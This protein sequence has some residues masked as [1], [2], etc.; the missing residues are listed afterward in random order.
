MNPPRFGVIAFTA[1]LTLMGAGAVRAS[2]PPVEEVVRGADDHSKLPPPPATGGDPTGET[3]GDDGDPS[4]RR[5]EEFEGHLL[6]GQFAHAKERHDEAI[7]EFTAALKLQPGDPTALIGRAQ[8]RRARTPTDRCPTRAIHDLRLLETYDPRGAWLEQRVTLLQW[9]A[10][11]GSAQAAGELA[12]AKEI[13]AEAP[14]SPGRPEDIRVRVAQLQVEAAADEATGGDSLRAAAVAELERYRA[15]C[16]ASGRPPSAEGLR[17]QAEIYRENDDVERA[18]KVYRELLASHPGS[19]QAQGVAGLLDDLELE[20]ELQRLN[21][22]RGFGPTADAEAAYRRG[23]SSFRSGDVEAAATQ[24]E[25]A[26]AASP[27]FPKAY[28]S[29]G[30]VR[31]RQARFAEAVD[32]LQR[33]VAMDPTDYQA[34]ITLGLIYKKEFAGAEDARAIKHLAAA[35]RLRPDLLVLH[36]RLGEL[37]ARTDREKAQEHYE[38][39]V[40]SAEPSDPDVGRAQRALEDL[41]REIQRDEPVA[42]MPPAEASLRA[43][44][45][46][47]QRIIN[48][49]YLR[50]T[51]YQDLAQAEKILLDALDRFPDEPEVYNQ[52][53]RVA[54]LQDRLGDARRYWETSLTLAADQ[55]EVHERIGILLVREMPDEAI[56]HLQRA[57]DLGSLTARY[58][59]AELLWDQTRPWQASPELDRYLAE[60]GEYEAHYDKAVALREE[61]DRRLLQYYLASAI[62]LVLVSIWPTW[63]I[64][65]RYRG[66]SLGQLLERDPKSFPEVARILSLIRHEIL[67]HNTAFLADVGS[68]LAVDDPDA[69][70]RAAVLAQ[71]LFGDG[72][73]PM[74]SDTREPARLPGIHGRF[75]GYV[76]ELDKVGRAHRVTL[77]LQRKDPIFGPMIHAFEALSKHEAELRHV[78]IIRPKRRAD[79]ARVLARAGEVL[80]R[81]AFDRLSGLIRELCVVNV[82]GAMIES[83]YAQLIGEAQFVNQQIAPLLVAGGGAPVRIFRTDLEDVLVNLLRNSLR[84]SLSYARPPVGLAVDLVIETD[85]ITGLSTLAIRIKDRSPEQLSNEMLR[86]RYVERGMGITVDLLSRYDGSIAVEPEP[87]WDKAVVVRLFVVEDDGVGV[88]AVAA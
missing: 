15:E 83:V 24:L 85:E 73:P 70:A 80:G 72:R 10:S 54:Y 31:A 45:P 79:L 8:S 35:L 21:E 74:P 17:L 65:R 52:L 11:C 23:L 61:I 64:Y 44:D 63:R 68:A 2:Q 40:R 53:A 27:W 55:V 42:I 59:L 86:G 9:M 58:L 88:G 75:L 82:D 33:A 18:A 78:G 30:V 50:G 76:E 12:L 26:I 32:A 77:N 60:A 41:E 37:Y 13:A 4:L 39:F 67:K 46:D 51:K 6:R 25:A 71:R 22:T 43:L 28:Y 69:D 1:V 34:H 36:M 56:P 38:R 29:L 66:K 19:S 16:E 7:R 57:A 5:V 62:L 81:Q 3:D 48:E 49:A 84:S 14:G 20:R 87:G 47:L